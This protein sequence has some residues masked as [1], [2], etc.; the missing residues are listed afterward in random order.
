MSTADRLAEAGEIGGRTVQIAT[1]G[2]VGCHVYPV[3]PLVDG[4]VRIRTVR[5]AISPGTE[6][7]FLGKDATNVYL[8]KRWNADLRL[9]EVGDPALDHPIT[10]GY[11]AAGIVSESRHPDVPVGQRVFGNWRHTELTAMPGA[12]AIA[13]ALAVDLTWDDGVDIGQMGP[14][15]VNAGACGEG[16]EVGRPAVV[17]GAGPI[18]LLTAQI[19]RAQGASPVHVVDRIPERLA[20]AAGLGLETLQTVEGVDVAR[21]L[22]DRH[23][24][25]GIPVAWECSGV[26]P[27][28]ADAIRVV[29]RRGVVVAVGFYQGGSE[30]LH[31]SDEFHHNAVSIVAGQ[32]GNPHPP[33][34]RSLLQARTLQLLRS[35]ALV[36]G[37]LPR[38]TLPVEQVAS[39]FEAL[40]R[41]AEVLQ[42]SLSY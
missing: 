32:I 7:T 1:T 20:I 6:M 31:L 21:V 10:F 5:T 24:G 41:P 3:A 29:G 35:G 13:Q 25:D 22:K 16:R 38:V 17:F 8:H 12:Q 19:V 2:E 30:M 23:G 39:A 40:R 18:G 28:L 14:I 15:C 37:G 42:V 4:F 33:Y 27:A 34:D 26:I 9:F 36:A 11:R